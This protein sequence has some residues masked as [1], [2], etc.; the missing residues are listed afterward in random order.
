MAYFDFMAVCPTVAVVGPVGL[1]GRPMGWARTVV[2]AAGCGGCSRHVR[3]AK[4][5]NGGICVS[6]GFGKAFVFGDDLFNG[7]FFSGSPRLRG[8]QVT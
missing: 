5:S 4:T 2:C 1:D 6:K 8:C 3:Q 7:V